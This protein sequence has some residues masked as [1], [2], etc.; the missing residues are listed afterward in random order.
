MNVSATGS[1]YATDDAFRAHLANDKGKRP[2]AALADNCA[3]ITVRCFGD[4]DVGSREILAG[5]GTT[6]HET[7][8]DAFVLHPQANKD[9]PV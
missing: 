5:F 2:L 8:P 6:Y 9:S 1:N 3:K 7:A 4:P